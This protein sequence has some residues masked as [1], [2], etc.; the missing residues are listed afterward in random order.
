MNLINISFGSIFTHILSWYFILI[1]LAI[2][3]IISL[4]VIIERYIF[5]HKAAIDT[6][7]FVAQLERLIP[8]RDITSSIKLCEKKESPIANVVKAALYKYDKGEEEM[9][10]AMETAGL[11]EIAKLEKNTTALSVVIHI[12]PLLGLLGTV[13]GFIGVFSEIQQSGCINMTA[14]KIGGSIEYALTTTAVGLTITIPTIIAYNYIVGRI[15]RF[16]LKMQTISPQIID[17]LIKSKEQD[18]FQ[19]SSK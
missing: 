18:E 7:A 3:S 12:A 5:F 8:E 2:C 14:T 4:T 17:I 15:Q 10:N 9:N 6:K 13:L 19:K 16:V 11:I 1:L